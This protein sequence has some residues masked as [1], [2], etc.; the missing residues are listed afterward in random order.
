MVAFGAIYFIVPRLTLQPW[1]SSA[2]IT[3]HFWASVA[4]VLII[5]ASL[6]LAGWEQGQAMADVEGYQTFAEVSAVSSGYLV[7]RVM[8]VLTLI[9]GNLAF[10]VHVILAIAAAVTRKSEAATE[11]LFPNPPALEVA[12]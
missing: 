7:A 1:P 3:A 2:L 9:V 5:V 6:G 12:K 8:G 11:V 10:L 4:G